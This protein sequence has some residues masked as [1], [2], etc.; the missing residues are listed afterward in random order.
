MRTYTAHH[1]RYRARRVQ[2]RAFYAAVPFSLSFIGFALLHERELATAMAI[3]GA[4]SLGISIG[5]WCVGYKFE[6]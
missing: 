6:D 5:A 3:M 1:V 2:E 4:I